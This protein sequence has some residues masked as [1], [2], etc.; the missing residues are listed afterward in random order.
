MLQ[1]IQ[2]KKNIQTCSFEHI[3]QYISG[4]QYL[5]FLLINTLQLHM[6]HCLI[7]KTTL[8]SVE[9]DII[10]QHIDNNQY[11]VAIIVYGKNSMDT[12]ADLKYKQFIKLGFTNVQLYRG[13]LFE[14]LLLQDIYGFDQ[15]KT[16]VK[17]LDIL[18]YK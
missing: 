3:Q 16:T 6:Q 7:D 13:G 5:P 9:E 1:W 8:A 2:S 12:S 4:F 14:W 10:N 15:F 17:V 18:K 11:D